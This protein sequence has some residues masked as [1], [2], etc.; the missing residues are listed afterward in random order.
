VRISAH[1]RRRFH[2]LCAS[3]GTV[4][5]GAEVFEAEGVMPVENYAGPETAERR[6]EAARHE[7][8]LD[9]SNEDDHARLLR[10]YVEGIAEFGGDDADD[11]DRQLPAPPTT[12]RKRDLLAPGLAGTAQCHR[13][14]WGKVN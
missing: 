7:A 11:D 12:R 13:R 1:T 10:V 5:R 4:R 14:L 3:H 9:F 6:F 2:D 8:S